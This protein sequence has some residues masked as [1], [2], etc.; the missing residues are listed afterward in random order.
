MWAGR[1]AQ[2]SRARM[3]EAVPLS[4]RRSFPP[5]RQPSC[6]ATRPL[7]R[8]VEP[9]FGSDTIWPRLREPRQGLKV[10]DGCAGRFRLGSAMGRVRVP[11]WSV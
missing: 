6:V 8:L 10:A 9:R 2:P 4:G 7:E 11:W 5:A 1:L 3:H